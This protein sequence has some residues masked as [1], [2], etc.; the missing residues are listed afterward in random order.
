VARPPGARAL[1]LF[2]ALF[3]SGLIALRHAVQFDP[4]DE[5][6]MSPALP[7]VAVASAVGLAWTLSTRARVA[8]AL[9]LVLWLPL[10]L[11]PR[12]RGELVSRWT[13][14]REQGLGVYDSPSWRASPTLAWART[15]EDDVPLYSN[16]PF[17]LSL[18]ADRSATA[19]PARPGG[20]PRL[21]E[22]WERQPAARRIIWF[23]LND[24][25]RLPWGEAGLQLAPAKTAEFTDAVVWEL[26]AP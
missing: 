7:F 9:L 23:H 16:E 15:L 3:A 13:R 11:A 21:F 10:A 8:T 25:A 5:R 26:D 22:Q 14:A 24:R 12:V 1:L 19:L 4:I 18:L 20:F 17:A 6:L 2:P